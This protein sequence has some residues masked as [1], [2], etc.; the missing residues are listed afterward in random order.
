MSQRPA[1]PI[2]TIERQRRASKPQACAWVSANAGSGKTHVLTQRVVRLLLEGVPPSRILCLTFTKAAAANMSIR[3]FETLAGWTALDNAALRE[4]ITATGAPEPSLTTLET[5]RKLFA[6][7]VETPGGLKIQTIH[8]FCERLLHLFPFEANVAARFSVMDDLLQQELLGTARLAMLSDAMSDESGSLGIAVAELAAVTTET[9]FTGLLGEML[10]HRA[11]LRENR[12]PSRHRIA[13]A[14]GLDENDTVAEV[15]KAMLE[16]GL[17][18]AEWGAIARALGADGGEKD[19]IG[20]RLA[21]AALAGPDA[22]LPSYL[23]VFLTKALEPRSDRYIPAAIRKG[24]PGLASRVDEERDRIAALLGLWRGAQ[25]LERTSAL[26]TV[27][28]SILDRYEAAKRLRGLLDFDDL[29]ERSLTLLQRAGAAWVL[30]KLD[31]GIDHVLVDEAQDT[32]P[33]QWAI[34]R[35]IT[36][37][38]FAGAGQ[39]RRLRTFFAVGDEKQSI[40]SFQG[41]RPAMFDAMRT[42]FETEARSGGATFDSVPLTLSFRSTRAILET[43]DRVFNAADHARGLTTPGEAL[44][45]HEPL[46]RTAPGVVELWPLVGPDEHPEPRDWRLPLDQVDTHAPPV[47][48]ARRIADVISG[49][50]TPGSPETVEDGGT[51]RRIRPGDIM[52]LVRSRNSFFDAVIRALKDKTVPVAGADRL[53]LTEHIAVMDLIAAGRAALLPEDDLT[54]ACVLKSPLLGLDDDDLIA[55]APERPGSLADALTASAETHHQDAVARLNTWRRRAETHSPF[56]F[57]TRLLGADGGRTRML[58]R[59]GPEAGDALDEFIALTLTH[60]REGAPSLMT[61]LGRLEGQELSIKRDME[62]AGDAVRVMTVHASKGLESKIVILPDTCGA[63]SGQHDPRLFALGTE[64]DVA[65]AWSPK[66]DSDPPAVAAARAALRDDA[67]AEHR[68]L[69][70]VALTRAEER[71]VVAGFHG[72]KGMAAGSWYG[73]IAASDLGLVE[74]PA[75]WDATETILERRDLAADAPVA[76]I[77]PETTSPTPMPDWLRKTPPAEVVYAP[78]IKPSNALG[79]ADQLPRETDGSDVSAPDQARRSAALIGRLAHNLLQ[80]LPDLAAETRADA[81][82]RFLDLHGTALDVTQRAA[83]LADVFSLLEHP[84]LATLFGPGSRAEVGI[85]GKARL[86]D[87]RTLEI[88]GQIDR[89]AVTDTAVLIADFKTGRPHDLA[90]V[91]PSYVLQLALY[92]ETVAPLY[93]DKPI[94]AFLVWTA[95]ASILELTADRLEAA[96]HE[97]V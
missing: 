34:L 8:A 76:A 40:F 32:S 62:A 78:P 83:L 85:A 87:G 18:R 66:K 13:A 47:R 73:M 1:I 82:R 3:I 77:G 51:R 28:R 71:L 92:R 74:V 48:L 21:D 30:Y 96:L 15:E 55:L 37:D 10:G 97:A 7:T 22:V 95:K 49:W 84:D 33:E 16:D 60:E 20:N 12:R 2:D 36:A 70:Y 81:A 19:S 35:A 23:S 39:A 46:R 24:Q 52:I 89:I 57:Y 54:L 64:P 38:F 45:P 69:L 90:T 80:H 50:V 63:P 44:L 26:V 68:R 75:P 5:A 53:Q 9:S 93:P 43:V 4:A 41:A 6:R 59:L 65:P 27:A 11:L 31:A 56:A 72:P 29:I 17:P 67:L 94:R 42:A 86:L 14:L 25:V 79:A 58:E 91:P 88:T 61:F